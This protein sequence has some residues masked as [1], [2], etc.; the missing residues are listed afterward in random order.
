MS[1]PAD[2]KTNPA[3]SG[4]LGA[5]AGAAAS[6]SWIFPP[7]ARG[8]S[9]GSP[10]G[11]RG[12]GFHPGIDFPAPEGTPVLAPQ[13]GRYTR[14]DGGGYGNSVLITTPA[15]FWRLAHFS[16]HA[17]ITDG[18]TVPAG[19]V[20]GY[21][22]TTGNSTGNHLH[23]EWHPNGGA[24]VDPAGILKTLEAGGA[25]PILPGSLGDAAGSASFAGLG[26]D[27]P[28]LSGFAAFFGKLLDPATWRRLA[29]GLAA[30]LLIGA[31][32]VIVKRDTI[33][34]TTAK[35]AA[36]VK[37]PKVAAVVRAAK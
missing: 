13:P 12:G 1:S 11:Q 18:A 35:A 19:A 24:P 27:L 34:G 30:V 26:I 25:A 37:A 14:S 31:G 2:A 20:V 22:G 21:V 28:D 36:V 29:L 23:V 8:W 3:S 6:Q 4:G 10:F 32:F 9:W 5:V 7:D 17:P 15:G 16:R 33:L